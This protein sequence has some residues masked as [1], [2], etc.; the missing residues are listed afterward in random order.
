[1]INKKPISLEYIESKE[2]TSNNISKIYI[3]SKEFT[4][5]NISKNL[6]VLVTFLIFHF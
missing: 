6:L 1:M 2:F 4:S 3:E 5:N